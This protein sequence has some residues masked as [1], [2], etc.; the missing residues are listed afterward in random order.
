MKL[1]NFGMDQTLKLP[2]FTSSAF[3]CKNLIMNSWNDYGWLTAVIS[4]SCTFFNDRIAIVTAWK[5]LDEGLD[6][7]SEDNKSIHPTWELSISDSDSVSLSLCISRHGGEGSK[8]KKLHHQWFDRV[9]QLVSQKRST[10]WR[11]WPV[12]TARILYFF[13]RR[14]VVIS[15]LQWSSSCLLDQ[16]WSSACADSSAWRIGRRNEKRV[17][18]KSRWTYFYATKVEVLPRLV[19]L[20][21]DDGKHLPFCVG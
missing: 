2:I 7:G 16:N 6:I 11:L 13:F 21:S 9:W 14:N 4:A 12:S 17:R 18:M 19:L 1:G 3:F 20:S 15:V 8:G 10:I 5:R